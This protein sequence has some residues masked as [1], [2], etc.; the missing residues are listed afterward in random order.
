MNK[1]FTKLKSSIL[2]AVAL[3]ALSSAPALAQ[4]NLD[5]K[6]TSGV[7]TTGTYTD[8]GTTGTALT[9][10]NNDDANSA[11][12]P[13]GFTFNFNGT[14]FT[15]FSLN[16]NGFIK[17]GTTAISATGPQTN[18]YATAF[19]D[20]NIIAPL[21][22]VDLQGAADQTANP[23]EF[24]V[25][26][27]GT[28]PNRVTTIQFKNLSDKP[29]GSGTAVTPTQFATI[30]FQVKLFETTNNIEFVYGPWTASANA[31]SAQIFGIGLKGSSGGSNDRLGMGNLPATGTSLTPLPWA[32]TR[33]ETI[34][35]FNGSNY[36]PTFIGANSSLPDPGR[37]FRFVK[38]VAPSNDLSVEAVFTLGKQA[39]SGTMSNPIQAI[40]KNNS[41][42]AKTNIPVTLA[43]TGGVAYNPAPV[44]IPTIAPGAS[45]TVTFPAY[46]AANQGAKTAT[47]TIPADDVASNNTKSEAFLVTQ[48][49]ISYTPT[50]VPSSGVGFPASTSNRLLL[51]RYKTE[52]TATVRIS[53]VRAYIYNDP[54]A[55]GKTVYGIVLD[56]LGA[57]I[58]RS[59]NVVLTSGDLDGYYPFAI[60]QGNPNLTNTAYYVGMVQTAYTAPSPTVTTA[61]VIGVQTELPQRRRAYYTGTLG[62]TPVK[63]TESAAAN[64][65]RFMIEAD[66]TNVTGVKADLDSKAVSVY[67]NPSKGVFQVAV[68]DMKG[69]NFAMEVRD[70]Q[71][72]LVYSGISGAKNTVIDLKNMASG[73]YI[74]QISTDSEI[75]VK[76][77]V[78]E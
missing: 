1:T 50:A 57:E 39:L 72:K 46:P 61:Y 33:F 34:T 21:S 31:A 78:V 25:V 27:T 47:V 55:V 62:T 7:N 29:S 42:V 51:N 11:V 76:R 64:G 28:A 30:N 65:F 36:I 75:A 6:A 66:V 4:S 67:P 38:F 41:T 18:I 63:P 74:L 23:T 26:T 10:A 8:L 3:V 59:A 54:N 60:T 70:L 45:V 49:T 19:P 71:G 16:T 48:N 24:R 58:G 52:G 17:L 53:T 13:I 43:V 40:I 5:Y 20:L 9:V 77:L 73:V 15:D 2:T 56:S 14:N 32:Q 12:T 37:T 44:T 35:T 69:S 68:N 22:G